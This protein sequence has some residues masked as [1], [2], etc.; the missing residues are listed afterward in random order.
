MCREFEGSKGIIF[1][2][3]R[4]KTGTCHGDYVLGI[5]RKIYIFLRKMLKVKI[6][7]IH[8]DFEARI[9]W[10][11][12][13]K[14]AIWL[15]AYNQLFS[16][17]FQSYNYFPNYYFWLIGDDVEMRSVINIATSYIRCWVFHFTINE[18]LN[19]PVQDWLEWSIYFRWITS[20]TKFEIA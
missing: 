13:A 10:V 3:S 1:W 9:D 16:Y 6:K 7:K 5:W 17:Y 15:D 19:V 18:D 2:G 8:V 4:A 12:E 14:R 11:G 20:F